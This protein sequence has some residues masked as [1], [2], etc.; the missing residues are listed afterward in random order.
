VLAKLRPRAIPPVSIARERLLRRLVA[1]SGPSIVSIVAPPG[2]GKTVLLS[3]W[4]ARDDRPVAWL[5]IDDGDN[6]PSALLTYL[7][8]AI[9]RVD[10]VDASISKAIAV[11][12]SRILATAV[13]RLVLEL[14]R[15]E[16]PGLLIIDDV[17]RLSDQTCLDI[18]GQVI[19][20]LPPGFQIALAGRAAPGLP[21]ARYRAEQ[22]LLELRGPDLALDLAET[23][24]LSAAMGQPLDDAEARALHGWTEGLA[25]GVYLAT[26]DRSRGGGDGGRPVTGGAGYVADYLRSEIARSVDEEG[27]GLLTRTSILEVVEPSLA[28]AVAAIPG[29]EERLA[30]LAAMNQLI[31]VVTGPPAAYRYHTLLRGYLTAELEQREPDARATLH[32][33]AAVWYAAAGRQALAVEHW[34]ASGDI[35]N[36]ARVLTGATLR[37]HY[38][39]LDDWLLRTFDA[40][41][42]VVMARHPSAAVAGAWINAVG[43]RPG[44]A[45]RLA[46]IAERATSSETSDAGSSSFESFRAI[47]RATMARYGL[48]QAY[49]DATHAVETEGPG[50]PWRMLALAALGWLRRLTGDPEGADATFVESVAA[51]GVGIE[52]YFSL[53][54]RASIAMERG[55][56]HAA[57]ALADAAHDAFDRTNL[58]DIAPSLLVHAVSARVAI[59]E[60]DVARGRSELVHAQHARPQASYALPWASVAGLLECARAYLAISDTA[61]ARTVLAEAQRITRRRPE[62]GTLI[63]GLEDLGMRTAEASETL[64]GSSTLTPAELR[65]LPFL[66]THL[67]FEE[68]GDRL[69]VSRHTIKTQAMSVYAKLQTSSRSQT[70]ERAVDLGLLEPFPGLPLRSVKDD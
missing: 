35:D 17:H 8:A 43:G 23:M 65:L 52:P 70:V 45:E 18:L 47:L 29:A 7:A 2:S 66:S 69:S 6:D 59:H 27:I 50:S 49:A 13:P 10:P 38:G 5:T 14:T 60:G 46:S 1:E 67:T 68:I 9:D 56:W 22:R 25:A 40:F 55:G 61:G 11:Q 34:L 39:G 19:D 4:E 3:E 30:T 53:A 33:R 41:D 28:E 12:G 15:W 54:S 44:P 26:L 37:M 62:L 20:F 21:L 32:R 63:A 24:A 51:A 16:R 57:R 58:G 42:D 64:V 36:A 31:S 48:A